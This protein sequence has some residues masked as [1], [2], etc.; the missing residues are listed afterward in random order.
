MLPDTAINRLAIAMIALSFTAQSSL[1]HKVKVPTQ[2]YSVFPL[3]CTI[4]DP[5]EIELKYTTPRAPLSLSQRVP[6]H[7]RV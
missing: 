7:F 1:Q 4:K 5:I 3:F 2:N 6:T